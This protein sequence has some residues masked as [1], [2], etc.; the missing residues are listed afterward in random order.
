M[1]GRYDSY[2][3]W[4]PD[5]LDTPMIAPSSIPAGF[6][7]RWDD[8]LHCYVITRYHEPQV[9]INGVRQKKDDTIDE[10]P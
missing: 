9:W 8:N 2:Y 4:N 7:Q 3:T 10:L 1:N 6:Q 5:G